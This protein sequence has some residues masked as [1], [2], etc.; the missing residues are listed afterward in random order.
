MELNRT[1]HSMTK[2]SRA[3]ACLALSVLALACGREA[4]DAGLVARAGDYELT[5]DD[6]VSLLVDEESL[7]GQATVVRSLAELWADYILLA[8]AVAEDSTFANVDFGGLIQPLLDQMMVLDLRDSVIQLDTSITQDELERLYAEDASTV[9]LRARHIL[10]TYPPQATQAQRDSVRAEL[11]GIRARV[12]AGTSFEQMARTYSQD[13]GTASAGGDLGYFGRGDMV[14]P[15]EEAAMQLEPGQISDVVQSPLGL[16]LIQLVDR[17]VPS[18]SDV[19]EDF[20]QFVLA[21]RNATAESTFVADL[22]ERASPTVAEGAVGVAR[23][24]ARS[25]DTRLAGRAADRPLVQWD[26][27]AF[28]AGELL[29]LLRAEQPALRDEVIRG[30]DEDLEG[31]LLAQARREL[32]VQEAH[33]AGLDPT[34]ARIDSMETEARSQL[35]AAARSIGLMSLDQA[36]GEPRERAIARAAREALADN[37]SGATRIVPLG[38]V[39]FQLREGVPIVIYDAGIGDVLIQVATARASRSPSAVEESFGA[40]PADSA[41]R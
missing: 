27:G 13:P 11:E 4:D 28:T 19:S 30:T 36:P 31:F 6:A 41:A 17:R 15:F 1:N 40:A 39:G 12:L 20:R 34:P 8:E 25:P 29:T 14:A 3:L 5:V 35:R 16:H 2:R 38:L 22:E 18:F 9:Q 7:P 37:L 32:L 26:G 10:L 33:R 24:L 23:E 21:Q